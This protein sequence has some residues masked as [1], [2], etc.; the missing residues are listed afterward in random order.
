MNTIY[1]PRAPT[2]LYIWQQNTRKSQLAQQYILDTAPSLYN[3]IL[4]QEPWLDTFGNA[5][6]NHHWHIIYSSNRFDGNHNTIRLIILINTNI[7]MDTYN[8]LTI[9]HSDITAICLKGDFGHCSIFNSYNNCTNN[10]TKADFISINNKLCTHLEIQYLAT[11]TRR[12]EEVDTAA[13]TIVNII[14][15]VIN[16]T[17][18][19]LS[20]HQMLVDK[21]AYKT[22]EREK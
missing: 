11:Q 15:E 18:Q 9:N 3:L 20:L 7:A 2:K 21:G 16:P 10:N 6:G 22:K 4:I 17:I 13:N 14:S 12:K 19:T 5:R 1:K 8:A